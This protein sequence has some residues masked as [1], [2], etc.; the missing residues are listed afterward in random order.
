MTDN[1]EFCGKH[2]I[3]VPQLH[4]TYE[5]NLYGNLIS[6]QNSLINELKLYYV[7][8]TILS[9]NI[10]FYGQDEKTIELVFPSLYFVVV[11]IQNKDDFKKVTFHGENPL[12]IPDL[13]N[14]VD[15]TVPHKN[16]SPNHWIYK[17]I[18]NNKEQSLDD[19]VPEKTTNLK[20]VFM[21]KNLL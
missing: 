16:N 10:S 8:F 1:Y 13:L 11:Q 19:Y 21:K 3:N 20:L 6:L 12:Y 15:I 18:I 14:I 9:K 2:T 7:D 17:T 4:L 5:S